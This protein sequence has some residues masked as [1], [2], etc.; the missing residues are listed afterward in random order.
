MPLNFEFVSVYQFFSLINSVFDAYKKLKYSFF[1]MKISVLVENTVSENLAVKNL[2]LQ[3]EHGLSL[4]IQTQNKNILF[5]MGQTNLFSKNASL[6]G[7]NLQSVDFAIL[8][9]G[10]YDHGG[11]MKRFLEI[12]Q[13]APIYINRNA[14]GQYYN[15]PEKYI[16]LDQQ[17]R[18][19]PRIRWTDD[20]HILLDTM[21]LLTYNQ[22]SAE[23]P[24]YGQGLL[25]KDEAGF[26]SDTF[27]HEQY[28][29]IEEDGKRILVSGCS[30]K[31]IV[32]LAL[33][34]KPDV[35]IGGFHLK[36]VEDESEL[37]ALGQL[38][39][40]MNIQFF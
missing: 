7:I 21:K 6:L 27:R 15:G 26:Q 12:N 33:W 31:G 30:H 35:V 2:P 17:M 39:K 19:E 22:E 16:G 4:F 25:Q 28:L 13:T 23:Y 34:A 5:D 32:N 11:G 38:L 1:I 3:A 9:H 20:E 14:F 40:N 10:H 18:N 37:A 8:S 24:N 29:L 36:K